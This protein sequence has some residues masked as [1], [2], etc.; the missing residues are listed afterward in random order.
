[1]NTDE[2]MEGRASYNQSTIALWRSSSWKR[3]FAAIAQR[4]HWHRGC[5]SKDIINPD[6]ANSCACNEQLV[7]Q[8]E[9][10]R[11]LLDAQE[12]DRLRIAG[13]LHDS[14]GQ[15]LSVIKMTIE[16]VQ[17]DLQGHAGYEREHQALTS[18]LSRLRVTTDELRRIALGLRPSMLEELGLLPTIDWCCREF[19]ETN[20]NLSLE[21][22]VGVK[23]QD[24]PQS[25]RCDIYRVLQ[26]AMH[27]ISK[28]ANAENVEITLERDTEGLILRIADDGCG[29]DLE[30]DYESGIGLYSMQARSERYGGNM[31]I[32]SAEGS[33]T[34]IEFRW[35]LPSSGDL[36]SWEASARR[37]SIERRI[38]GRRKSDR[39]NTETS[40][41]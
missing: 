31:S 41:Q 8:A 30:G 37:P 18:A 17:S 32:H 36:E 16:S 21:K 25:L 39:A 10:S 15:N 2:K 13:D 38:R 33:G 40:G 35:P 28:H 1:M 12:R 6:Q 11:A 20:S 4:L 24:V 22:H 9:I 34:L 27:N 19:A 26:E 3:L 29:F 23:E 5:N 14:I 7:Y